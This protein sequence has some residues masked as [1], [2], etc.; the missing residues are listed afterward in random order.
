MYKQVFLV[1][2]PVL[3][4]FQLL[5]LIVNPKAAHFYTWEASTIQYTVYTYTEPLV[6][7]TLWGNS[8]FMRT[9]RQT[10]VMWV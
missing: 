3:R 1:F 5:R 2:G 8:D 7:L 4:G 9:S 6:L 10:P